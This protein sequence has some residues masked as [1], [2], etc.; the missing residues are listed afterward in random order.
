MEDPHNIIRPHQ[1]N[2]AWRTPCAIRAISLKRPR[3]MMSA[4]GASASLPGKCATKTASGGAS[5]SRP[6]SAQPGATIGDAARH[7]RRQDV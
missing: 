2:I 5:S 6:S 4:C 1:A 7:S 3:W